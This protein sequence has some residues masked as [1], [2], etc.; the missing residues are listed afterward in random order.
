MSGLQLR[1][2]IIANIVFFPLC[3]MF[4]I[5]ISSS[6]SLNYALPAYVCHMS[7][8]PQGT[9]MVKHKPDDNYGT[10]N[11]MSNNIVKFVLYYLTF[12]NAK[13]P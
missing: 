10:S 5:M 13:V 1:S 2:H 8:A 6:L 3:Q 7:S 9:L 12:T 4:F 11:V